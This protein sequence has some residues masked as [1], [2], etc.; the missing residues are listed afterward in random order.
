MP[1][2]ALREY[3][4]H[5]ALSQEEL[6]RAA[7]L[8]VPDHQQHRGRPDPAAGVDDGPCSPARWACARTSY[9]AW[10]SRVP[11]PPPGPGGRPVPAQLPV[12][13]P[14]FV[15]RADH[16]ARLDAVLAGPASTGVVITV[17]SGTAGVGKPNPGLWHTTSD[18]LKSTSTPPSA[19]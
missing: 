8:D 1:G 13:V 3:R 18:P 17:L 19:G 9:G 10:P 11:V 4:V 14:S 12:D 7:G 6:A 16:L 2:K 15:G 5:V